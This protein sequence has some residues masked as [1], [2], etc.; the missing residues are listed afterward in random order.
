[1]LEDFSQRG[2]EEKRIADSTLFSIA[3][4]Y[5]ALKG[6]FESLVDPALIKSRRDDEAVLKA[7]IDADPQMKAEFG[8]AWDSIRTAVAHATLIRDRYNMLEGG[9]GLDSDLFSDARILVRWAAESQKP[10]SQRLREYTDANFP[11]LRQSLLS[12][13]PIYPELE[14]ATFGFSL[15]LIQRL[16][17]PDDP[18]VKSMLGARAPDELANEL[19]D[20]T[21]LKDPAARKKLLEG[22]P[23]AIESSK[24]PMIA[25]A[26][27]IDPEARAVRADME[28]NVQAPLAKN[29]GL[30]AQARFK[31]YGPSADPDATFT[32]RLS[33]GS[34]KGY[35]QA[36]KTVAPFTTF[37]GAFDRAT[38]APPFK[39]PQSWIDAKPHLDLNQK[40]NLCTT[41]DIIGGNSGSPVINRNAEIVGLIFDGNIQS[42][43]GNFGYDGAVN[44]AVAVDSGAIRA[45]LDKIYHA[46]RLV[47]ELGR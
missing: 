24:D 12:A 40:L 41:N 27:L 39:L 31:L 43:G 11:I 9:Q 45:A 36:G 35:E 7:K 6:R 33:Y 14:K 16:L 15:T 25:F 19:I 4:S 26:R 18:T 20:R 17:G 2:P 21:T 5:K 38:G 34:V 28:D 44:R 37:A 23:A 30:I 10:D 47:K 3:N 46:D 42:L 29:S 13:A 1:L 22:G 8:A 32:L